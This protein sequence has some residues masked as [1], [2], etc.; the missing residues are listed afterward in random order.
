MRGRS[1]S[2][3]LMPAVINLDDRIKKDHPL[4]TIKKMADQQLQRLSSVFNE[5]YPH[6]GRQYSLRPHK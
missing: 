5:M 2:Q 3:E 4:R 6:A 1:Q